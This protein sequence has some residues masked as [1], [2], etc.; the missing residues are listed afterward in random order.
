MTFTSSSESTRIGWK[1]HKLTK[2]E[3]CHSNETW[4]ALN[5]TF[6]DINCIASF[7]INPHWISNSRLWKGSPVSPK[8]F[9]LCWGTENIYGA[10][11]GE[12]GGQSLINNFKSTVMH[13]SHC[14]QRLVRRSIVLVK[15]DSLR[16][17]SRQFTYNVSSLKV[18]N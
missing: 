16:Q 15:Q 11:S 6:P 14:N 5:S 3:L 17:F 13:S 7:Q 8:Q 18:Q 1:V 10:K 2:K 4:H 12:N 9:V